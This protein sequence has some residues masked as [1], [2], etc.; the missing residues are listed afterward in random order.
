VD[1]ATL[2]IKAF[3]G[4]SPNAVSTQIWIALC[5]FVLAAIVNK[6]LKL[7]L[8]LYSFLQ[9]LNASLFRKSP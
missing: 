7:E 8:S 2:R 9:I 4:T 1:Q 5:L 6:E 3:Y